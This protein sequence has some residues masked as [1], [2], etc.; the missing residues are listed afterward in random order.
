MA[1]GEDGAVEGALWRHV[2]MAI[3]CENM[4]IIFPVGEM[5]SESSGDILQ[6]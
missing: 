5:G 3:I 1:I 6:G 2:D 4:V